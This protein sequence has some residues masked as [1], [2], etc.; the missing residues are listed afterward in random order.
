[1]GIFFSLIQRRL[2]TEAGRGFSI[3]K[4]LLCSVSP[5]GC[6]DVNLSAIYCFS[7]SQDSNEGVSAHLI[8]NSKFHSVNILPLRRNICICIITFPPSSTGLWWCWCYVYFYTEFMAFY[9]FWAPQ[10]EQVS[11]ASDWVIVAGLKSQGLAQLWLGNPLILLREKG[12]WKQNL[13]VTSNPRSLHPP[14][15]FSAKLLHVPNLT[16]K[17]N[18]WMSSF[19]LS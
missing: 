9:V 5:K 12:P 17:F 18:L 7:H 4:A 14:K 16:A 3:H 6:T 8:C 15:L 2:H 1:M 11:L 13:N 10:L 19:H